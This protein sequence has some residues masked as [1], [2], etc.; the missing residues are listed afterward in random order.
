MKLKRK[1]AFKYK[2]KV[3]DISIENSHS[4]NVEGISVHNSAAGTLAGYLS[5]ITQIDPI[6]YNLL[7]ERFLNPGRLSKD[8]ISL[9]DIDVDV[10]KMA[11]QEVIDYLRD[12]Y[13]KDNVAQILTFTTLKGKK[14]LKQVM[15]GLGNVPF[16]IQNA[17]TSNLV[18]ESF[19]SDEL[20]TM[21]QDKGF[22]S[23]ILWVLE[24]KPK[25]LKNWVH[26]NKEGEVKGEFAAVFKQA[27]R[28]E[29][30]K[31]IQ[32]SHAAGVVV[33]PIPISDTCP[34]VHNKNG[35]E[36]LAGFEGPS[37]EDV[38]L[39]KLDVL[40]IRMLDKVMRIAELGVREC[41]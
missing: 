37:C 23:S 11:R 20:E 14:A 29:Y 31:I 33:S 7:F 9:P 35:D 36:M 24:N 27:M 13:G 38:G 18:D 3:N 39:L 25:S 2:G 22:K 15:G 12:K 6:K 10:P 4:Y 28:L 26:L 1:T 16:G 40:G 32:S 5:D 8:H 34:M 19:I 30:T 41:C 17:I 21:K